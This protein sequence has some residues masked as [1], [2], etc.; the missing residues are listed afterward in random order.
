MSVLRRIGWTV[1]S[2]ALAIGWLAASAVAAPPPTMRVRGTAKVSALVEELPD[3]LEVRGSVADD[4]GRPVAGASLEVRVLAGGG[5]RRFRATTACNDAAAR[6]LAESPA[7]EEGVVLSGADGRFCLSLEPSLTG[8]VELRVL[9]SD[10]LLGETQDFAIDRTRRSL[11]LALSTFGETLDVSRQSHVLHI[12]ATVVPAFL[13]D[14]AV[15]EIPLLLEV[16]DRGSVRKLAELRARPNER[17]EVEVRSRDM[18]A[19]GAKEI[20]LSFSGASWLKPAK[21]TLKLQLVA[22]VRLTTAATID[23]ARGEPFQ[24]TVTATSPLGQVATGAVQ[25]EV[26]GVFAGAF[27]VTNGIAKPQLKFQRAEKHPVQVRYTF[28]P[29]AP[30]LTAGK[31]AVQMV[32]VVDG[33]EPS[34]VPWLLGALL[35]SGWI[36]TAWWRPKGRRHELS[37]PGPTTE[38]PA[39]PGLEFVRPLA[40]DEGWHGRVIDAHSGAALSNVCLTLRTPSFGTTGTLATTNSNGE[41][42]FSL[43]PVEGIQPLSLVVTAA[44]HS[45][46]VQE[47]PTNGELLVR[48]ISRR[49]A[50]LDGLVLWAQRR[51]RPW[52][53]PGDPTPGYVGRI[54]ERHLSPDVVAWAEAVEAAAFGPIPVDEE[55][56]NAAR[57]REPRS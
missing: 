34:V 36:L 12:D 17:M 32:T 14:D 38:Q 26:N 4:A 6:A 15:H 51:G 35:A 20:S 40:K 2:A 44:W 48:L 27:S 42:Y 46:L 8:N 19:P 10:W 16:H 24:T 49:R 37:P 45:T 56:E 3:R 31:P 43:A 28:I 25:A 52:N 9:A 13:S 41:G 57:T 33:A 54:A 18:G 39:G 7:R 29:S 53:R 21:T 23:A 30:Y 22:P 11:D 47:L 5:P 55:K 1:A 50:L